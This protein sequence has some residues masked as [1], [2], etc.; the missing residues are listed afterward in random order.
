MTVER[1]C[2]SRCPD[3]A[4]RCLQGHRHLIHLGLAL[5]LCQ[6]QQVSKLVAMRDD[7]W[8][9]IRRLGMQLIRLGLEGGL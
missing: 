7:A 5:L 9:Q 4:R 8:R 1:S 3:A 2:W 6:R